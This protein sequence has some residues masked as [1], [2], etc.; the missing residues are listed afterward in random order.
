MPAIGCN[1]K[2]I[3]TRRRK[4]LL[5]T[6]AFQNQVKRKARKHMKI[7]A[8][9]PVEHGKWGAGTAAPSEPKV[10]MCLSGV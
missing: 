8:G 1:Q 9:T 4:L 6:H 5:Q 10:F 3:Q 2:R 7:N